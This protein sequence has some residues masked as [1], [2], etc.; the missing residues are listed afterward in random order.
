MN[1]CPH[2]GTGDHCQCCLDHIGQPCA[3]NPDEK[4]NWR[5]DPVERK[6]FLGR[7]RH[8]LEQIP[9][10]VPF[11]P[12]FLVRGGQGEGPMS[13]A[14][15]SK[16]PM[17]LGVVD[18]LDEREKDGGKEGLRPT[19]ISW[20]RVYD[21][22][23]E[24]TV[25]YETPW[26]RQACSAA[27]GFSV[28]GFILVPSPEAG[29]CVG[30]FRK[31]PH[32]QHTVAEACSYLIRWLDRAAE[33]QWFDEFAEVVRKMRGELKSITRE[34][35]VED[36]G[37]ACTGCGWPN[38]ETM[39]DGAWY[40]CSGCGT[41]FLRDELAKKA[42]RK[43]PRSLKE[44]AEVT[45]HPHR[46]LRYLVAEKMLRHVARDGNRNLYDIQDVVVAAAMVKIRST[47]A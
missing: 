41:Q 28:P 26:R 39:D 13:A 45:G 16:P 9:D 20:I 12:L 43:R 11:I 1:R 2:C 29:C 4:P 24:G 34:R 46:T 14:F 3:A 44:C 23:L 38:I 47:S 30:D 6:K 17:D 21:D 36:L 8:H 22:A 40:R 31:H 15:G 27:C 32:I 33:F 42:E 5:D 35:S 25:G 18:L 10:L 37:L 19:L 7:V